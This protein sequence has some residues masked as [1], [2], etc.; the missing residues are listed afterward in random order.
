M[1]FQDIPPIKNPDFYL[2]RAFKEANKR[3]S[4]LRQAARGSRLEKSKKLELEKLIMVNKILSAEMDSII[5]TFPSLDNL[6][7]FYTELINACLDFSLLKKALGGLHW[8]HD[9]VKSLTRDYLRKIRYNKDLSQ[10]NS[11]RTQYYGR[12]SSVLKQ[13]KGNFCRLEEARKA[14]RDFPDIK[15]GL[16]TVAIAG[17]PNVGKSTLLAKL[18]TAR[19]KIASYPFTTTTL[20]VGY[21]LYHHQD[22][23]MID[24]PG[25]LNRFERMNNIEKQ[26]YLAMKYCSNLIIYIFD[27]T[28]EYPLEDQLTLFRLLKE[29]DKPLV[30]FFSKQDMLGQEEFAGK[31]RQLGKGKPA[32]IIKDID[33]LKKLIVKEFEASEFAL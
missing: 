30:A 33:Q 8:C 20:N 26:A 27:L 22:I 10:F 21:M 32:K 24:T 6:S 25:T 3:A 11:L 18:T 12:V 29:Y 5:K 28:E 23:Q 1:N 7:E 13:N 19:P 2:D 14:M 4:S 16:F 31:V 9:K 15:E 17:F